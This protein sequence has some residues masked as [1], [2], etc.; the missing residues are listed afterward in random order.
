[1]TTN[2]RIVF[3]ATGEV[4][5]LLSESGLLWD[6]LDQAMAK[7]MLWQLPGPGLKRL[8]ASVLTSAAH[9]LK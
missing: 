5:A 9:M 2:P 3:P 8:A 4:Y 6:S 7:V 1:M